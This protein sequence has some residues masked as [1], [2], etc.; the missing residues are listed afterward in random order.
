MAGMSALTC[1]GLAP[2]RER[3]LRVR[4]CDAYAASEPDILF[5]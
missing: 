4:E 3:R 5:L 2:S 1:A